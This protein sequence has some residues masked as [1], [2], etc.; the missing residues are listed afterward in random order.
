MGISSA[1][2]T[3][4]ANSSETFEDRPDF[5]EATETAFGQVEKVAGDV[6][7]EARESRFIS[8]DHLYINCTGQV[9]LPQPKST[10]S[11]RPTPTP[12]HQP[13]YHYLSKGLIGSNER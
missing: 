1:T 7:E 6:I 2:G 9:R 5:R 10:S 4:V 11:S 8:N 13:P 12:L 3:E